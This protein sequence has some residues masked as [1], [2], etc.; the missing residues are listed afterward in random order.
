MPTPPSH[1]RLVARLIADAHPVRPLWSPHT[2]FALW[3][4][5]QTLTLG[6]AVE[7]GLRRDL[8]DHLRQPLFLL[9]VGALIAAGAV[10]A[11]LA[12]RAAV[13]G[14]ESGRLAG[15]SALLLGS[16][17]LAL[18]SLEPAAAIQSAWGFVASGAQCL[19]C[20][21]AFSALPW[22]ALF[23][24]VR[25]GAPLEGPLAGACA[26]AAAFL[27][28]AAAVRIACPIDEALH[29]LT[30]HAMPIA[31]GAALSGIAGARWLERWDRRRVP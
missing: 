21:L 8:G 28:A 24:A 12:L 23:V 2:R 17:A 31:A 29:L 14:M 18:A 13:P 26:G 15:T 20:I 6:F 5:L 10:A 11:A 27:F 16:A 7:F 30:W 25:R 22:T 9:E 1:E 4:A 3:L 19:A